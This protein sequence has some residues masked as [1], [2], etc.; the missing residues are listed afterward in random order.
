MRPKGKRGYDRSMSWK[1]AWTVFLAFMFLNASFCSALCDV[2][3]A[4]SG[5]HKCPTAHASLHEH[6]LASGTHAHSMHMKRS[7]SSDGGAIFVEGASTCAHTL[8]RQPDS[9]VGAEKDARIDQVKVAVIQPT[10]AFQDEL[11]PTR[12]VS[13]APPPGIVSSFRPLSIALRI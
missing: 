10:P 8:C 6:R 4:I 9:V 7:D 1:G 12:F 13:E 5:G 3:C 11:V 2:T